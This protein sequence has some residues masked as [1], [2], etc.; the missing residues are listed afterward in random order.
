M[1]LPDLVD[2]VLHLFRVALAV[3]V[4]ERVRERRERLALLAGGGAV[5]LLRLDEVLVI[6]ERIGNQTIES[7]MGFRLRLGRVGTDEPP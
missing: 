1:R 3:H 6:F 4:L 2:E 5:A 7:G